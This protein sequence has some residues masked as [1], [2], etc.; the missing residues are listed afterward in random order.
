MNLKEIA[1]KLK[2]VKSA[3]IFCHMRPDGDALGAAMGLKWLLESVGICSRAVCESPVPGKFLF[4]EGMNEVTSEADL[5]SEA[6]IA[7]D[8]SD[9]NRLGRLG[10]VFRS[11]KKPK[12]NIDHHISNTR[13]ADYN[14]VE[15]RAA[16]CEII[17][18]LAEYFPVKLS[19]LAADY[20]MMGLS[21]DTG[22]FA[23]KNVTA[24]TFRAAAK[25]AECGAD[26][27]R[28]QY[29]MFKKQSRE[30]ARLFGNTM[31][32]IRYFADGRI[33]VITVT[34]GD[35]ADSGAT[36]DMTEGFIDFPLNIEG[37][38]VALCLLETGKE[39]FKVSLRSKGKADVNQIASV[40]GGGG[41]ILA[42]GCMVF[43]PLEEVVD[44]LRYTVMQ[45]L[46]D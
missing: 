45:H 33:A 18:E 43:G 31:S 30:R 3:T 13:F 44:K 29:N 24:S 9:E 36:S 21:S 42:S 15:E 8:S 11:A 40:Y 46:P 26:I 4:L 38:E 20:L 34:E 22:N 19:P 10:E 32:K 12:F 17:A 2:S 7:V 39:R 5:A 35:L 6:F 14:F 25:L 28:I 16:T 27:N 37:V 23:H 41:H 1:E